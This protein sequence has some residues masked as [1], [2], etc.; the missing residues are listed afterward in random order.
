M[1]VATETRQDVNPCVVR[2]A[3][4]EHAYRWLMASVFELGKSPMDTKEGAK[5]LAE[6]INRHSGWTF[7]EAFTDHVLELGRP[8]APCHCGENKWIA[9]W[10][11]GGCGEGRR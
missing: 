9:A 11:C 7:W 2:I 8:I 1:T 4:G 6:F 3:G 10:E 5:Q